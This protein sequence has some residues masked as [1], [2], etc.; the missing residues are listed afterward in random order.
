[1]CV[2]VFVIFYVEVYLWVNVFA[3]MFVF[4]LCFC[5][6]FVIIVVVLLTDNHLQIYLKNKIAITDT[7]LFSEIRYTTKQ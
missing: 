2:C 1:M 5:C 4:L 7:K 6:C 3:W